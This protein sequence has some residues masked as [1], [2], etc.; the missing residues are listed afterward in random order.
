MVRGVGTDAEEFHAMLAAR[1]GTKYH[2]FAC[3]QWDSSVGIATGY[4][5]DGRGSNTGKDKIFSLLH[6]VQISSSSLQS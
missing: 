4:G 2:I 6:R 3:T 5:L 1:E